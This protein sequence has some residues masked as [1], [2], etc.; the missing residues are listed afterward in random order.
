M[1][2]TRRM[3]AP[4]C[5]PARSRR[6]R[7]PTRPQRRTESLTDQ[8]TAPDPPE[9]HID[10]VFPD[11]STGFVA[12]VILGAAAIA[13]NFYLT[14]RPPAND[15]CTGMIA[16][17]VIEQFLDKIGQDVAA[18]VRHCT[19]IEE[20]LKDARD[21]LDPHGEVSQY[22]DLR[23]SRDRAHIVKLEAKL[24]TA[25]KALYDQRCRFRAWAE[26]RDRLQLL[27]RE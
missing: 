26:R 18:A 2:R 14:P 10:T 21:A 9:V 6:L 12:G 13:S 17:V 19:R 4:S 22:V 25:K 27:D 11:T 15:P 7:P 23:D 20:E 8:V 5:R 16:H 1:K 24:K 3:Q